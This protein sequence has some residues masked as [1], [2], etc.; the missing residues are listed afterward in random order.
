MRRCQSATYRAGQHPQD[1]LLRNGRGSSSREYRELLRLIYGYIY[2]NFE[3][4]DKID[5]ESREERVL[6]L[7]FPSGLFGNMLPV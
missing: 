7:F 2:V 1:A 4:K 5:R 3:A 6:N